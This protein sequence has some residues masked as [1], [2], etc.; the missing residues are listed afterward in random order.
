M[1]RFNEISHL[2]PRLDLKL[3]EGYGRETYRGRLD[4]ETKDLSKED[5]LLLCNKNGEGIVHKGIDAF[6][7]TIW[8]DEL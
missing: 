6:I 2:R 8:I 4:E 1:T 5:L 3:E 7:A